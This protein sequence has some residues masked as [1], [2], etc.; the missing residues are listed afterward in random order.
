MEMSDLLV[1][2]TAQPPDSLRQRLEQEVA[3][4]TPLATACGLQPPQ[5]SEHQRGT[6][7]FLAIQRPLPPGRGQGRGGRGRSSGRVT[8]AG[9][10]W[11]PDGLVAGGAGSGGS[12]PAPAGGAGTGGPAIP[13]G[14]AGNPALRYDFS[15]L[16]LG[17]TGWL[18]GAALSPARHPGGRPSAGRKGPAGSSRTRPGTGSGSRAPGREAWAGGGEPDGAAG[19]DA[20][21]PGA[22]SS[23]G[24][25]AASADEAAPLLRDWDAR[26]VRAL[27]A[28]I[29]DE[30]RWHLMQRLVTRRYAHLTPEERAQAL[31]YARRHL[32]ATPARDGELRHRL[33][34][35]VAAYLEG[36]G[37][38]LIDGFLRFRCRDYVE[39]LEVAV[40]RAVDEYLLDREYR[41]FVGLLRQFVDLQV[42][43]L[44][45][46]HVVV[47][48]SGAFTLSD[49]EGRPVSLPPGE[50]WAPA[51]GDGVA[52][53][54]GDALLSAL[55]TVAARRF[56][57]HLRRRGQGLAGETRDM[58]EQVFGHR[59]EVC[60]GCARCRSR[61]RRPA[62]PA[63]SS[64]R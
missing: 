32:A 28:Y 41:D 5:I 17:G 18:P 8:P 3:A 21:A 61:Q 62:V 15:G 47:E 20:G 11:T 25:A 44:E 4:F 22:G 63:P 52:P 43:R 6:W 12:G 24:T 58:L 10:G 23:G 13:A 40:D 51:P 1:I 34:R 39:A 19:E 27:V 56:V 9:L 50:G 16:L 7:Y 48:P 37:L 54:A 59:I 64:V 2:G 49:E 31:A 46:V 29:H 36:A 26:V 38:L 45:V 60:G 33:G 42:P 14:G 35:Q 57:V 53:D 30:H 55:V